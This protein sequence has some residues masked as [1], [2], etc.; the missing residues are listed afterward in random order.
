MSGLRVYP[1]NGYHS[2]TLGALTIT[3]DAAAFVYDAQGRTLFERFGYDRRQNIEAF[4]TASPNYSGASSWDG[5]PYDVGYTFKWDLQLI[6]ESTYFG[7]LALQQRQQTGKGF[8]RLVDYLWPMQED[9]PRKRAKKG[10]LL[11]PFVAGT[12]LFYPQFNLINFKIE[13]DMCWQ[14]ENQYKNAR[15]IKITADEGDLDIPVPIS[16]DIS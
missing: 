1:T 8:I 4:A 10:P 15:T 9:Q 7:L 12:D 16:A 5:T 13:E 14:Q 2:F 11:T 6:K 3:L